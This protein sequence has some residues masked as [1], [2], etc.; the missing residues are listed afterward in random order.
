MVQSL[1]ICLKERRDMILK[2][3]LMEVSGCMPSH[4]HLIDFERNIQENVFVS[5]PHGWL[6]S[7][8]LVEHTKKFQGWDAID[9]L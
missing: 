3:K 8:Q 7:M 2:P 6:E 5:L 1:G 4:T 9:Y